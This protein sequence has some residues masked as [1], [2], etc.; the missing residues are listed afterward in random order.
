VSYSAPYGTSAVGIALLTVQETVTTRTSGPGPY[1]GAVGYGGVGVLGVGL[2]GVGYGT[3]TTIGTTTIAP[4]IYEKAVI[5][6]IAD[7]N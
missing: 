4:I 3:A 5:Q 1:P 7:E 2:R 6:D